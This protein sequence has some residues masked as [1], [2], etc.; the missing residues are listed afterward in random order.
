MLKFFRSRAFWTLL[1]IL[2][3]GFIAVTLAYVQGLITFG[4]ASY[5]FKGNDKYVGSRRGWSIG[6]KT[7]YLRQGE[8]L[9]VNYEADVKRGVLYFNVDHGWDGATNGDVD[10]HSLRESGAG[11]FKT[12][13]PSDGWYR[14]SIFGRAESGCDLDYFATWS[15]SAAE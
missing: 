14:L 7:V 3:I 13:I 4:A 12:T 10:T 8:V 5:A 6:P 2:V 1:T 11:Q 9:T 15:A